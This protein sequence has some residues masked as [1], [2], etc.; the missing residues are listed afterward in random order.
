MNFDKLLHVFSWKIS[1]DKNSLVETHNFRRRLRRW[2]AIIENRVSNQKS[3]ILSFSQFICCQLQLAETHLDFNLGKQSTKFDE[4]FKLL[5]LWELSLT[6]WELEWTIKKPHCVLVIWINSH[7][8][9]HNVN[10]QRQKLNALF[11]S[12]IF[13]TSC[14]DCCEWNS[15]FIFLSIRWFFRNCK[16]KVSSCDN[17]LNQIDNYLNNNDNLNSQ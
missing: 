3:E 5:L 4:C 7:F 14:F 10:F 12:K 17:I 1:K 6:M 13:L 16:D 8:V 9:R 11:W 2:L 15:S